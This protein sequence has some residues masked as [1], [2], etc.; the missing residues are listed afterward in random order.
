M[1][2]YARLAVVVL[3]LPWLVGCASDNLDRIDA[4]ASRLLR[5][6][7]DET[8]GPDSPRDP[9]ITPDRI[10]DT[11][12]DRAVY[13]QNPAT[14]NPNPA[15]LP[16][17]LR[18]EGGASDA[19]DDAALNPLGDLPTGMKPGEMPTR[20]LNLA[21][22][23]AYSIEHSREYR[24]RKE[25]LYLS[26]LSLL[27]ERHLWGPRFFDTITAQASGT[28]EAG[29][30]DQAMDIINQFTVTQRLPYGG[31]VS[32]SALV[33]FVDQLRS[34]STS[35]PEGTS[36]DGQ[37]RFAATI[38][39]LRGAGMA[40]REDLI[41]SERNLVYATRAF[42]R[43]RREFFVEVVTRYFDLVRQTSTIRN[44][45]RQLANLEWL[46]KRTEAM[47][48][49]GRLPFFEV[50]RAEQS[51]LFGRNNLII[52]RDNYAAALDAFKLLIGMPTV[53]PLAIEPTEIVIPEP[54]INPTEA[55]TTALDLRLDLQTVADLV[56]DARRRVEV[57]KNN[58]LPDLDAF[59]DLA[60]RTDEEK[61]QAGFDLDAGDSSYAAGARLSLPLDRQIEEIDH[62]RATINYERATRAYT[63]QRDRVVL[64]VRESIRSLRQARL[65][66][67]LQDRN[68]EIADKRLRGIVLR[69]AEL[70]PRDFIE[71]QDDQLE[72]RNRRDLALRDLRVNILRY[73]LDTG[74]VRV[75]A[76]GRWAPPAKMVAAAAPVASATPAE[77]FEAELEKEEAKD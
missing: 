67:E 33:S 70:G 35:V 72:A 69:L 40:A 13:E 39:L 2:S 6:R 43:F 12:A 19:A 60:L 10:A 51:V 20:N 55:V 32:A 65:S 30:H 50:Q 74:Q 62:R 16:A 77:I 46:Q 15:D 9:D 42:E 56:D 45:E 5:E 61:T 34:A 75:D 41:Q 49:A 64:Q 53:E 57:A 17:T 24:S 58:R 1:I 52:I 71:A 37:L 31:S 38:P 68:I 44:Q 7:T 11:K 36:Q 63:F 8:L 73:L 3:W 22:A 54:A 14:R 27:A 21:S 29:D 28:P 48:N 26:T 66:L 4:K 76:Q 59:A 23:L 18:P 25:D 47:A